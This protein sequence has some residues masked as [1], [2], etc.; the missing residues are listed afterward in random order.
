VLVNS[1]GVATSFLEW[2]QNKTGEHWSEQEVFQR[3]EPLMDDA[4]KAV[5]DAAK[6][7]GV[8]YREA[9]FIVGLDRIR[10]AMETGA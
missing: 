10:K 4:S 9:A 2:E 5:I 1:G 7:Y 3:L 6:K 8:P